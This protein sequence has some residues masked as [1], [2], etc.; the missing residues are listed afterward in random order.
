MWNAN[1]E[2]IMGYVTGKY[3]ANYSFSLIVS[4]G[5]CEQIVFSLA[6]GNELEA[7]CS[8]KERRTL[9]CV[10]HLSSL[11]S[12]LIENWTVT[13]FVV[14]SILSLSPHQMQNPFSILT[15]KTPLEFC[16]RSVHSNFLFI[17]K[18]KWMCVVI[19]ISDLPPTESCSIYHCS[20]FYLSIVLQ[21]VCV[22]VCSL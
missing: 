22:C 12:F 6:L 11:V 14:P 2:A 1:G 3:T 8:K 17:Q 7:I 19:L 4:A 15:A 20:A 16:M 9:Y 10:T 13:S 18:T 5:M 21:R